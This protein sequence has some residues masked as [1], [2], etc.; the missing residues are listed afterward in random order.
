M[1]GR[2]Q[3]D[4]PIPAQG[5]HLAVLQHFPG[6]G[7]ALPGRFNCSG[8]RPLPAGQ[9]KFCRQRYL[10]SSWD[11]QLRTWEQRLGEPTKM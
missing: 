9:G 11:P 8:L 3:G 7:A 5:G 4:F 2:A 10:P 6:C 1:V